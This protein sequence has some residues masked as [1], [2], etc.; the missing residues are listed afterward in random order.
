MFVWRPISRPQSKRPQQGL[1]R[2]SPILLSPRWQKRRTQLTRDGVSS[3]CPLVIGPFSRLPWMTWTR[4]Q[5]KHSSRPPTNIGRTVAELPAD[6]EIRPFDRSLSRSEFDCGEESLNRWLR[7]SA[8]Q[9]EKRKLCRVYLAVQTGDVRILG[10][11]TLSS[12]SVMPATLP[13]REGGKLPRLPVPAALLGQLAVDTSV[14]G[15][16]VGEHLLMDALYRVA[17][18][19]ESIGIRLIV[20]H[21]IGDTARRFYERYGFISFE[22]EQY[23]LFLPTDTIAKLW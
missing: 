7:E 14:Q 4:S 11:Y 22:D 16:H 8:N 1:G 20:V 9:Y 19:A 5:T 6:L 3:N 21:A 18:T 2:L 17:R 13:V 12:Y 23:H 15:Q 10:Y